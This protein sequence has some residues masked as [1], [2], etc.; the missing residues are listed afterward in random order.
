MCHIRPT[1][2]Q[3]T[4]SDHQ[5]QRSQPS[6]STS[7]SA[8]TA[9]AQAFL[10]K[11]TDESQLSNAAAAAALRSHTATPTSVGDVQTKRMIRRGS[12]SSIGSGTSSSRAPFSSDLQRKASTGSMTQRSFRSPSP[13]R[14]RTPPVPSLPPQLPPLPTN[15]VPKVPAKSSK[16]TASV[17]TPVHKSPPPGPSNNRPQSMASSQWATENLQSSTR[18]RDTR[19]PTSPSGTSRNIN[20][21]RPM[22]PQ[23]MAQSPP[24]TRTATTSQPA[25]SLGLTP[26][27]YRRLEERR[28]AAR[29]QEADWIERER[30]RN[31]AQELARQHAPNVVNIK[32]S[33]QS[34][35]AD[36]PGGLHESAYAPNATISAQQR[37]VPNQP[38]KTR[39]V[40][41]PIGMG[42][43]G[44]AATRPTEYRTAQPR[45]R[46]DTARAGSKQTSRSEISSATAVMDG[47]GNSIPSPTPEQIKSFQTRAAS[48]LARPLTDNHTTS[49]SPTARP[50]INKRLSSSERINTSTPLTSADTRN[51]S[52]NRSV[53]SPVRSPTMQALAVERS[54]D[55]S[56]SPARSARFSESPLLEVTKHTPPPRSV[57]PVKSAMKGSSPAPH[58][59]FASSHKESMDHSDKGSVLSDEGSIPSS[60]KRKS[61]RVS[62]E[63]RPITVGQGAG[64]TN[65][66]SETLMSPQYRK[67]PRET[68]GAEEHDFTMSPR[69]DLPSFGSIRARKT[70]QSEPLGKEVLSSDDQEEEVMES[71]KVAA[72]AEKHAENKISPSNEQSIPA[73]QED[74]HS[75]QAPQ[76]AV[77]PATPNFEEQEFLAQGSSKSQPGDD[78]AAGLESSLSAEDAPSAVQSH[79][80]PVTSG[81]ETTSDGSNNILQ[82]VPLTS[83]VVR[84][85]PEQ[86]DSDDG[87][88]DQFSDAAE[89]QSELENVGGFSSL[90]AI[91]ESPAGEAAASPDPLANANL[92]TIQATTDGSNLQSV[93]DNDVEPH[94]GPDS[95]RGEEDWN[96]TKAYWSSLSEAQ[97]RNM[98]QKHKPA[99]NVSEQSPR[100]KTTTK[101]ISSDGAGS[102]LPTKSAKAPSKNRP[103]A[104]NTTASQPTHFRS[105]MRQSGSMTSSL[106]GPPEPLPAK[107]DHQQ[108]LKRTSSP[109]PSA[110]AVALAQATAK[111]MAAKDAERQAADQAAGEDDRGRQRVKKEYKYS[112]KSSMRDGQGPTMRSTPI[113]PS[114]A[115]QSTDSQGDHSGG[116]LGIGKPKKKAA[117][118]KKTTGGFSA[119]SRFRS[120]FTESSD[121]DSDGGPGSRFDFRSRFA[122]SDSSGDEAP[123]RP[124]PIKLAPVR[125]IPRTQRQEE[126]DSTELEDSEDEAQPTKLGPT[127]ENSNFRRISKDRPGTPP[128]SQVLSFGK[129]PGPAGIDVSGQNVTPTSP[130][131]PDTSESKAP[132]A[133]GHTAEGKALA[134]GTLREDTDK[135]QPKRNSILSF[136]KR[137]KPVEEKGGGLADSKWADTPTSPGSRPQTPRLPKTL[138]KSDEGDEKAKRHSMLRR[139]SIGSKESGPTTPETPT[140][141]RPTKEDFPFPPPPI[142]DE[143][144][145]PT[146]AD[147]VNLR[148]N[149]SD[150]TERKVSGTGQATAP[151]RPGIG[152]K[153]D[154]A[155]TAPVEG[156]SPRSRRQRPPQD[157]IVS[158]RTGKKK[159]FQGLRRAFGLND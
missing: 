38:R 158:L 31:E 105:S 43:S 85:D 54:R 3:T 72:Q 53:S 86:S 103:I 76:I 137:S 65:S 45:P 59:A 142:P 156:S 88:S 17:D 134:V 99:G 50:V 73:Y 13:G 7:A 140:G 40:S 58:P 9:A 130:R 29:L 117:K 118:P 70:R 2:G 127:S 55:T 25:S 111:S 106:R 79:P 68:R 153:R 47:R 101:G 122:D 16:R 125:G 100:T 159:K 90:D 116:F 146:G 63:E 8:T 37:G 51:K 78:S 46:V 26:E 21:S 145:N 120:R 60:K 66:P 93:L 98:E 12:T 71:P 109:K 22:S 150:G 57:S 14:T 89:D 56:P 42:Q 75:L 34:S 36:S 24:P 121:E 95:K 141:R 61:V 84:E 11:Q 20:F 133:N 77:L 154:S 74:D 39:P 132:H 83:S 110:E 149:T 139:L 115:R 6:P 114:S 67:Q 82:H 80:K 18:E 48:L 69:P 135:G 151:L 152:E 124:M 15:G 49:A 44:P 35:I 144:R 96:L 62:F 102:A 41:M 87:S 30:K 126:G 131:S 4:D 91:L 147:N 119:G 10:K 128:A 23:L 143:Y 5:Q 28:E 32:P 52:H 155:M 107:Q 123:I 138:R 81:Q 27:Q 33:A 148:P 1:C 113:M 19:S 136:G 108:S 92:A 94:S 112:M 104:S 157:P 129:S 64:T 97:K